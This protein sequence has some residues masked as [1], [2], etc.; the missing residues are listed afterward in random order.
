MGGRHRRTKRVFPTSPLFREVPLVL[1]RRPRRFYAKVA[2]HHPLDRPPQPQEEQGLRVHPIGRNP[3]RPLGDRL[4]RP[5]TLIVHRK[6]NL[7]LRQE[8][9]AQRGR[10]TIRSTVF[11]D[12]LNR[13]GIPLVRKVGQATRGAR[14]RHRPPRIESLPFPYGTRAHQ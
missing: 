1:T 13:T 9:K 3:V 5:T 8:R 14:L 2:L 11:P 4:G 7:L 10:R 12:V 6:K